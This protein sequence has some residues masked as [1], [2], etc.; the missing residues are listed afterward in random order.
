MLFGIIY[1]FLVLCAGDILLTNINMS[2]LLDTK[3]FL[4][5]KFEMKDLSEASFVLGIQIL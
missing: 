4:S 1:I 2:L 3:R 5:N